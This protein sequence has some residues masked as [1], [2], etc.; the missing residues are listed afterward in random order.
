MTSLSLLLWI[1]LGIALQLAIYLGIVFW[2][3]WREYQALHGCGK[4]LHPP[5]AVPRIAAQDLSETWPGFRTF[6][7]ERKVAEDAAQS[8]CSFYLVPE[9]GRPLPPF[10]PGQFL[11]FRL[12]LPRATGGVE[13]AV[14]CHS[15]SDSP[16]AGNYR[17]SIKRVPPTAG[18]AVPPGRSS[19]YFHD[20][21]AA[22]S[23]LQVRAP[24]GRF[25][26]DR[27]DAPVVLIAGGIGITPLLS[28][29]NWCV[30]EQPRREVWLFY[31]V[32][33]G[34]ALVPSLSM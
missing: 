34:R 12:D 21:V 32:R 2:R 15:L 1:V 4:N 13:H 20:Q 10:L 18:S 16:K 14:R 24:A 23:L 22:G 8:V 26:L 28:I 27:S 33:D 17:I 19:G 31:G 30:A 7:V 9:D 25:C 29:L 6:R 5:A 3:R 11:T